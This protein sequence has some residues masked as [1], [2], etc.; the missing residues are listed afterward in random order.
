VPQVI[1]GR[2]VAIGVP[3]SVTGSEEVLLLVETQLAEHDI[4]AHQALRRE[5]KRAIFDRLEFMPREV[6]FVPSGW[7]V[8]TTSGKISRV[9]NL[10][11]FQ[12]KQPRA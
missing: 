2:V 3:D 11:R 5:I 4:A 7:L 9:D 1:S 10:S 6:H 8:K 12:E